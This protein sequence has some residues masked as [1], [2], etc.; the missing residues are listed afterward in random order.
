VATK[1]SFVLNHVST[2]QLDKCLNTLK[3]KYMKEKKVIHAVQ[4]CDNRRYSAQECV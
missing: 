2:Q 4:A 1:K 3:E